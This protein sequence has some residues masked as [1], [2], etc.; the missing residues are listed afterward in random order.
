MAAL[1]FVLALGNFGFPLTGGFVGEFLVLG[2]VT[3]SSLLVGL[4]LGGP[5][6]LGLVYTVWSFN[7]AFLGVTP[8][9]VTRAADLTP[10]EGATLWI[11]LVG[12]LALGVGGGAW[13]NWTYLCYSGALGSNPV[14]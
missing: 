14:G 8:P 6:F 4:L 10:Q 5:T 1:F 13:W 11:G 12:T 3:R 7:R 2:E 9:G